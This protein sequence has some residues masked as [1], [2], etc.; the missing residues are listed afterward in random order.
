[1][2]KIKK[3]L[4][5]ILTGVVLLSSIN[6]AFALNI[7]NNQFGIV[8]TKDLYNRVVRIYE[9]QDN[10][11]QPYFNILNDEINYEKT[12]NL[13]L[14]LGME[15][16]FID[17]L[18]EEDLQIYSTSSQII[19]TVSYVKID[20]S[21]K[22]TY[23]DESIAI[24]KSQQI[25]NLIKD[26]SELF[27]F[28]NGI[29]QPLEQTT[30]QD[31]Y[32]RIFYLVTYL[33]NGNYKY[34][35]DARWLTMPFFR[36]TDSIGSCAQNATVTNNTR[37]GWY[38]YDVVTNANGKITYATNRQNITSSSFKNAINGNWYGSVALLKLP[39]DYKNSNSSIVNSNYKAHYEYNGHVN[40]P[41]FAS[42]F[43]TSA[44]YD[45][46]TVT[47]SFTP[48]IS[49][50]VKKPEGSIGFDI[51]GKHDVRTVNLELYYKPNK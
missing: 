18:S 41:N 15:Q 33:G 49:I 39:N 25:N 5:L 32:M 40:Y 28:E 24:Q 1:M 43:N 51:V 14:Q 4:L 12:K 20:S 50:G 21:D 6:P 17:K 22:T 3:T 2:F 16:D 48:T 11:I 30:F 46:I 35:T 37:S 19:G 10:I 36:G 42:W 44:T 47:I 23:I 38:E 31:S 26:Q 34:S 27:S 13:L 7:K 9:K 29:I 45:H 8:E